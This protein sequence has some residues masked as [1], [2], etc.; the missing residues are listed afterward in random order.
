M[1]SQYLFEVHGKDVLG[2][3]RKLSKSKDHSETVEAF[4]GMECAE[5]VNEL[6]RWLKETT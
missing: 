1:L 6:E 5:I 4:L 2:L 3:L